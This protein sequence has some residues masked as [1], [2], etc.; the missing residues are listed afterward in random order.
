MPIR[1]TA[2]NEVPSK[3]HT[4]VAP[5]VWRLGPGALLH[6]SPG[7]NRVWCIM[8]VRILERDPA[9]ALHV[10][11]S[12]DRGTIEVIANVRIEA[13]TAHL[14]QLHIDG[15]GAGTMGL[16]D[17]HAFAVELGRQLG[18]ARLVIQGGMRT[19]G[20][21]P[22]HVPRPIVVRVREG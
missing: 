7:Y 18:V 16:A 22:G 6:L 8:V 13:G 14:D 19:T 2:S 11:G 17:L 12:S 20:A 9:G 15:P 21:R 4:V 3:R 1:I 5:F 10:Q